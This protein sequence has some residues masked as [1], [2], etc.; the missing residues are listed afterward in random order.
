[1][2]DCPFYFCL[3]KNVSNA[4]LWIYLQSHTKQDLPRPGS[5]R[6]IK[7]AMALNMNT[8]NEVG[9]E[10]IASGPHPGIHLAAISLRKLPFKVL[11][12]WSWDDMPM[13]KVGGSIASVIWRPSPHASWSSDKDGWGCHARSQ[14]AKSQVRV[15]L[16]ESLLKKIR[17]V[18][19]VLYRCVYSPC[20]PYGSFTRLTS[21]LCLLQLFDAKG[22]NVGCDGKLALHIPR[23]ATTQ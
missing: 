18:P 15:M 1:M 10:V 19:S 6:R 4:C 11:R 20:S 13:D 8:M 23:R 21:V 2:W 12:G 3:L 7:A 16:M 9:N 14:P 5:L 22:L 17:R